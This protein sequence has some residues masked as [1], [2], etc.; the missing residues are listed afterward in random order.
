LELK[1]C[2]ES[3]KT[4]DSYVTRDAEQ[5]F[6]EKANYERAMELEKQATALMQKER[7]LA[8]EKASIY[9]Q[10]YRSATKKPGIGCRLARIFTLGIARCH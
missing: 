6:R 2:R 7:D 9:E 8:Q 1:S 4:Y 10:L 5:D 3:I